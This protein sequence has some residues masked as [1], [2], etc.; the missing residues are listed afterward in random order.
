M[1]IVARCARPHRGR[2][3]ICGK[4]RH[5]WSAALYRGARVCT[6]PET[7]SEISE[8]VGDKLARWSAAELE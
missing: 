8:F 5:A 2:Y 1:K 4:Y 7:V 6:E 3:S